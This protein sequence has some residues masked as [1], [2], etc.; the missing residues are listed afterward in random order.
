[1][2]PGWNG[3]VFV[4]VGSRIELFEVSSLVTIARVWVGLAAM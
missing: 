2:M 3:L 4:F 1:M